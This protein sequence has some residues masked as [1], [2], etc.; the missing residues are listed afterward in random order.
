MF[1]LPEHLFDKSAAFRDIFF[2]L[3][4][5]RQLEYL[6]GNMTVS[7][8]HTKLLHRF[9]FQAFERWRLDH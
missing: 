4:I 5:P 7:E 6:V 8:P 2:A 1:L 3:A 9:L